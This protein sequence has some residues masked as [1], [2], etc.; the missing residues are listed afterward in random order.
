MGEG[1]KIPVD[2]SEHR[3][4]KW[5]E[6]ETI[7]GRLVWQELL[8]RET[9]ASEKEKEEFS[10]LDLA[11]RFSFIFV[12][13]LENGGEGGGGGLSL[14]HAEGRRQGVTSRVSNPHSF[15]TDPDPAF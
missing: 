4:S 7:S 15:D 6:Q 11:A 3:V 8:E 10:Y 12:L 9:F 13:T 1:T 14:T 5:L 2:V